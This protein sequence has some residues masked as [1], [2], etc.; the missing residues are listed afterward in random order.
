MS[1]TKNFLFALVLG[2][3]FSSFAQEEGAGRADNDA[4][5]VPSRSTPVSFRAKPESN[6]GVSQFYE[7][8]LEGSI[9]TVLSPLSG[10]DGVGRVRLT[11]IEDI[12]SGCSS[13]G[14]QMEFD[15]NTQVIIAN[16]LSGSTRLPASDLLA[17]SGRGASV[18]FTADMRVTRFIFRVASER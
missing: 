5:Q 1:T 7:D 13:C 9:V 6:S 3:T 14:E 17:L 16:G 2:V 10:D 18:Y 8:A 12:A 4:E 15:S 11:S